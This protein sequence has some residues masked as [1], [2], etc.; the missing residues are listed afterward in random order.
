MEGFQ[1]A[2]K[3]VQKE[4]IISTIEAILEHKARTRELVE[5]SSFVSQ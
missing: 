3:K 4:K 1:M 5:I 2:K